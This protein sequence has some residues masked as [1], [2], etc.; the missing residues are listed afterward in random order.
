MTASLLSSSNGD[1]GVR[2]KRQGRSYKYSINN[3]LFARL[4]C[5]KKASVVKKAEESEVSSGYSSPRLTKTTTDGNETADK[6][7]DR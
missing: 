1:G 6:P 3:L 5:D 4:K 2:V 7:M